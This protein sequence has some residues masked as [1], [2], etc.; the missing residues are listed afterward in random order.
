[1]PPKS[2]PD[3]YMSADEVA[4]ALDVTKRTVY[5]MK[6]EGLLTAVTRPT[7]GRAVRTYYIRAEVEDRIL[8]AQQVAS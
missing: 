5:R 7:A 8:R 3:T 2:P 4:A 1:M 6:A